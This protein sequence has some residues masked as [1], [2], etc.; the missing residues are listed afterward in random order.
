MKAPH[1]PLGCIATP[2]PPVIEAVRNLGGAVSGPPALQGWRRHYAAVKAVAA[3]L[4]RR[5]AQGRGAGLDL[6]P[7]IYI[8][9]GGPEY[10]SRC[11]YAG[12]NNTP[13]R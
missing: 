6:D 8:P 12:G 7:A 9:R 11:G 3:D 2:V 1:T 4:R 5:V 10:A 13:A